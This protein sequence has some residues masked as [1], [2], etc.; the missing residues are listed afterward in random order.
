[1]KVKADTNVLVRAITGDDELQSKA[2]Q[3][4]L[5]SADVVALAL[6]ALCEPVMVI[7]RMPDAVRN[8]LNAA[9]RSAAPLLDSTGDGVKCRVLRAVGV[10]HSS[11]IPLAYHSP[12]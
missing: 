11:A 6:P 4:E 2:A 10:R 7:A 1:M 3:S 9:V 8:A 5:A 12:A